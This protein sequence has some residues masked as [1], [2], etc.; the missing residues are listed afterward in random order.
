MKPGA[1]LIKRPV[2]LG[3]TVFAALLVV[4]QWASYQ[5]YLLYQT[6]QLREETNAANVT[7]EKL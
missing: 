7:K 4:T 3:L 2:L 5:H 6:L 1:G